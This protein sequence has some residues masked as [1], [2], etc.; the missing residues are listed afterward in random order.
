MDESQVTRV[1]ANDEIDL[2]ELF[3][4]LW[5][6]KWLILLVTFFVTGA[7]A[8]YAFLSKPIYEARVAVLPPSLSN[9]AGF[10]LG[11]TQEV[12][13][14]P[15]K[16]QDVY[17]VFTRNLQADET[18]RLFFEGVYLPSLD[19]S[20]RK[21][22][23]DRLY[24]SFSKVLS[25]KAP[26]KNQPNRY[27]VVVE[28][29]DP[30]VAAN[31]VRRY[32]EDV[33]RRSLEEMIE[34]A[35]REIEVKERDVEQRIDSLRDTAKARRED[36]IIQLR[37]ALTVAE[38]V[39]LE[40]TPVISGQVVEQLSAFM[41]GSLMYMRGSKALKA[42]IQALESRV[43]DDPFIPTLRTLQE[44]QRLFNS[45]SI[46]P[47]KVAV[48]RQDGYVETPDAPAKPK[49][50]LILVIGGGIGGMLGIFIALVRI[51]SKRH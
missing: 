39:G 11:R 35:Q 23:R 48:F 10:N 8:A 1:A 4:S 24:E 25:I 40:K 14:E 29:E 18:R 19:E 31:W 21:A 27:Q 51:M 7:A 9:V 44:Q 6:Q 38:A 20:E 13:L 47:E 34:N 5:E 41:D 49:K 30:E 2:I 12:G 33:A 36:R 26:D 46:N 28:H 15:F 50:M 45:L 22:P 42:E 3:R 17:E 32:T 16:V 37:E 43:S